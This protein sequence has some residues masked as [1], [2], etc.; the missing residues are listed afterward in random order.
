MRT[1]DEVLK[2]K[3]R[4][5]HAPPIV[6]ISHSKGRTYCG[7]EVDFSECTFTDAAYAIKHYM[8]STTL[9]ACPDCVDC[10]GPIVMTWRDSALEPLATRGLE[11]SKP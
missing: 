1:P 6:C 11:K 9:R 5:P 4:D 2:A 8:N 10:A 3:K 7:R